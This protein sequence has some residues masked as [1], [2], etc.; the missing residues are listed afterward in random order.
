M[1]TLHNVYLAVTQDQLSLK[2]VNHVNS[3]LTS[4]ELK[5]TTPVN[6]MHANNP[7]LLLSW[8]ELVELACLL[9]SQILQVDLASIMVTNI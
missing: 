6:K 7:N 4:P 2:M 3:A 5:K 1:T 8:M 9:S